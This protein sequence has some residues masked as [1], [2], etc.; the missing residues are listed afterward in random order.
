MLR[1]FDRLEPSENTCMLV[2]RFWHFSLERAACVLPQ[3]VVDG[4]GNLDLDRR[5]RVVSR[6]QNQKNA[7]LNM[8]QDDP[9]YHDIS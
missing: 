2:E 5:Q 7:G 8:K 4:V 6:H 3:E 1:E 9:T